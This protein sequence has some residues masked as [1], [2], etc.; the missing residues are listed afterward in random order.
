MHPLRM[1][2]D[3]LAS[4]SNPD[5]TCMAN[6]DH[7][8]RGVRFLYPS[9]ATRPGAHRR[10]VWGTAACLGRTLWAASAPRSN[11]GQRELE[12]LYA[13]TRQLLQHRINYPQCLISLWE[14]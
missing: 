3:N 9:A 13:P 8:Q 10:H 7:S 1:A 11:G 6:M 4:L 5:L 14:C 12:I 2:F